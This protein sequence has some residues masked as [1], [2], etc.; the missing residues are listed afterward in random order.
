MKIKEKQ[1]SLIIDTLYT[2]GPQSRIDI[3][4]LLGITPATV[5]DITNQL[6][7]DGLIFELGEDSDQ[8]T[9]GR[10]KILL[11]IVDGHSYYL[12]VELFTHSLSLCISNNKNTIISELI[13]EFKKD[14]PLSTEKIIDYINDFL[15]ENKSIKISSIGFAIP[16]H[17][18]KD[19]ENIITNNPFWSRISL[20][21]LQDAFDLPVF[22][23]NNVNCMALSQRL[24]SD[25]K[26]DPNFLYLHFRK[27]IFCT[28]IYHSE[29]YARDNFYVGEIG[30]MVVNPDGALCECGKKGCLQTVISQTWLI[31]RAQ[32]LY[33]NSTNTFLKSLVNNKDD[34]SMDTLLV[35][36]KMGDVAI[37]E[38]LRIAID[39]LATVINNM[40]LTHDSNIIYIHSQIFNESNLSSN[41]LERIENLEAEYMASKDTKTIITHYSK[42][43]G[44][45]SA[46]AFAIEQS[47]MPKE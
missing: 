5:S 28:Y 38:M 31:E 6:I 4:K 23:E 1:N 36:Y 30:H 19:N 43:D 27:G 34:I 17:Y 40:T 9:A 15:E 33:E 35:A 22:F 25:I 44:A 26:T 45:R 14:K 24:F 20:T 39:S 47:L 2:R 16:G 13:H 21:K 29:I 18:N 12:G 10:R 41:L 42:M 11:D 46:C 7:Q 37:I 32:T 8:N 3:S